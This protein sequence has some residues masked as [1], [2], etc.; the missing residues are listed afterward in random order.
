MLHRVYYCNVYPLPDCFFSTSSSVVIKKKIR[1][2]KRNQLTCWNQRCLV[3]AACKIIFIIIY[4]NNTTFV[5]EFVLERPFNYFTHVF[6]WTK[7]AVNLFYFYA[8][9][10]KLLQNI[11]I[12]TS[13]CECNICF[14]TY[15]FPSHF[16]FAAHF[17]LEIFVL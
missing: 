1:Y 15:Y 13:K 11:G 17:V 4:D 7:V 5:F 12:G 2:L 6:F 14:T 8:R 10:Q 9:L 16:I 3:S